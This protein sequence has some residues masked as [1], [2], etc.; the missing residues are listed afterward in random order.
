MKS[1][2]DAQSVRARAIEMLERAEAEPD[3]EKRQPLLTFVVAGGGLTGVE[4]MAALNS[5]V[6]EAARDYRMFHPDEITTYIFEHGDRLLPELAGSLADFARRELERRGVIVETG[7]SLSSAGEDFVETEGKR[8]LPACTLI[9]A[10]GVKPAPVVEK[11]DCKRGRHGGIVVDQCCAVVDHQ[12]IWAIGDC[13]EVP[14]PDGHGTYSPT[15]QNATRE[16]TAVAE[17]IVAVMRGEP[18]QPFRHKTMGE[19]ALVGRHSGVGQIYNFHFSGLPAWMLWRAVYLSK[20]PGWPQRARI[21]CDWTL[22]LIFGRQT[23]AIPPEA[24]SVRPPAT[25]Q[26]P[27]PVQ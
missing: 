11:L 16:G 27:S 26:Q 22:D 4:T 2:E 10:A 13:A 18:Q 7:V 24:L 14:R 6:R 3:R 5:F 19:M 17:N 25:A 9:W 23:A 21:L 1:L 12:G 8:R 20:M 15:A